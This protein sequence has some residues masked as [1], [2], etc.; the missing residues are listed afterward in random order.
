[1]K[2]TI[3]DNPQEETPIPVFHLLTWPKLIIFAILILLANTIVSLLI[4]LYYSGQN[5][6]DSDE[7]ECLS[8]ELQNLSKILDDVKSVKI[9]TLQEFYND[10]NAYSKLKKEKE[11]KIKKIQVLTKKIDSQKNENKKLLRKAHKLY[12]FHNLQASLNDMKSYLEKPD[13]ITLENLTKKITAINGLIEEAE[14]HGAALPTTKDKISDLHVNILKT[15]FGN[16]KNSLKKAREILDDRIQI[17][18]KAIAEIALP[19]KI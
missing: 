10:S 13:Q 12:Y 7:L 19:E 1:M 6:H 3:I 4:I 2:D 8:A 15:L 5:R 11:Q 9:G 16:D 17:L 14:K 18:K